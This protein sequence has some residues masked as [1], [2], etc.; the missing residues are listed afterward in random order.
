MLWKACEFFIQ[1][2]VVEK[3]FIFIN[4]VIERKYRSLNE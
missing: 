1:K 2:R 3:F 4:Y